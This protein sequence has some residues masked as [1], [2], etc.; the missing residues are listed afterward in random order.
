MNPA[1][2][3]WPHSQVS[4]EEPGNEAD[5]CLQWW[6]VCITQSCKSKPSSDSDQKESQAVWSQGS[7]GS[8]S[9]TS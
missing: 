7:K 2:N 5:Q 8:H 3:A 1:T 4:G 6:C 9:N